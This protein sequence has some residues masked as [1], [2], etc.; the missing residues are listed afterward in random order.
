MLVASLLALTALISTGCAKKTRLEELSLEGIGLPPAPTTAARLEVTGGLRSYAGPARLEVK[1]EQPLHL[2]LEDFELA[3]PVEILVASRSPVRFGQPLGPQW[4]DTGT[5]LDTGD[6]LLIS[7]QRTWSDDRTEQIV[8]VGRIAPEPIDPPRD[9]LSPGTTLFYGLTYDDKPITKLVPM[10]LMVTVEDAGDDG[11]VF[12]WQV[13][14]DPNAEVD[15]TTQRYRTGRRTISAETAE[16]GGLHS[17]RFVDGEDTVAHT[18]LFA[19]RQARRTLTSMGAAA[20]QDQDAPG[21][22]LL[23]AVGS[24]TVTVQADDALWTVPATVARVRD[25]GSLYV[26]ADDDTDPLILWA[27]RPGWSMRLMA[28]GRPG[29]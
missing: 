10:G 3:E 13:D 15:D 2:L 18:S 4:T 20:W 5:F 27:R 21:S 29:S 17:D 6:E 9:W 16:R 28:I 11:R 19:P 8:V 23:T 7:L 26:I 1:A 22:E 25:A 14:V 24:L 12:S